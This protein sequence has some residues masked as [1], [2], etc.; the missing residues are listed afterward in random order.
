MV[1]AEGIVKHRRVRGRH[2]A[3]SF[4]KYKLTVVAALALAAT[5]SG[6]LHTTPVAVADSLQAPR[7]RLDT[8]V[9][10]TRMGSTATRTTRTVVKPVPHEVSGGWDWTEFAAVAKQFEDETRRDR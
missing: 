8:W 2:R 1:V 7:T 5:S 3:R 6:I 10:P 4:P 9:A